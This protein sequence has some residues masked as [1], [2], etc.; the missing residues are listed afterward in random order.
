MNKKQ[1][2][3]EALHAA[4]KK[5]HLDL[6]D[7]QDLREKADKAVPGIK[8]KLTDLGY[9]TL[10][11]YEGDTFTSRNEVGGEG[12]LRVSLKCDMPE[13]WDAAKLE[14]LRTKLRRKNLEAYKSHDGKSLTVNLYFT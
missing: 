13:V 4:N 6:M 7:Y 8:K 5:A 1:S 14:E 3:L 2:T 12:K 9:T 10:D 11:Q